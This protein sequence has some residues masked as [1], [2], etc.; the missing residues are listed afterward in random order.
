MTLDT[1]IPTDAELADAMRYFE[2]HPESDDEA[3]ERIAAALIADCDELFCE[4]T[5][6]AR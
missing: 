2:D 6:P 1:M 3:A 5:E 4:T